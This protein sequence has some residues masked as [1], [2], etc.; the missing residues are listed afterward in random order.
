MADTG[1][2]VVLRADHDMRSGGAEPGGEG[3][4]LAVG[5][6]LD[7]EAVLLEQTGAPGR[8]TV[9]RVGE[10][11]VGGDRVRERD[12]DGGEVVDA[13]ADGVE[14]GGGEVR[15]ERILAYPPDALA[16]RRSPPYRR[17]MGFDLPADS[18]DRFMGRFSVPL[19]TLFLDRLALPPGTRVLDVGCGPGA[20]TA[21]LVDRLGPG[22]VTAV[23]PSKP[24]VRAAR[25]RLPAAD[26]RVGRAEALP[27]GD[28]AYDACLAQ[29]V[30]HFLTDPVTGLAEMRR[31]TRPGG[32]VACTV[33]DHAGG[34]GPLAAFWQAV[35][36]VDPAATGEAALPG[37]RR[38]HLGEPMTAAELDQVE[39]SAMTV[40]L[41][42]ATLEEWWEPFTLGVGPAGD[43]VQGLDQ[44][45]RAALLE[46]C[47]RRL[48]TPP[49]EVSA[50]AWCAVATV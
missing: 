24:F 26:V 31:V 30:V 29:L 45:G 17:T 42:F 23:D 32:T 7:L 13:G 21:A 18:Y 14:L 44:A 3:G 15:H 43:Y 49:F 41:S 38:G 40:R 35:A 37:T 8:G 28:A 27:V 16:R 50:T 39:E 2:G 36:E 11:R 25:E 9:L 4:G 22:L 46:A 1:E 6:A 10:L 48:P 12:E 34:G 33:W 47:G 5:P 20:L 19:A